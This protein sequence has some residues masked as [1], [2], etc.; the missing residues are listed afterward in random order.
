MGALSSAVAASQSAW[1][2]SSSTSMNRRHQGMG[3]ALKAE[4][5]RLVGGHHLAGPAT[6]NP[7]RRPPTSP[8]LAGRDGDHVL[9]ST[10]AGRGKH[11]NLERDARASVTIL[12][13]DAPY[14]DVELR[15]HTTI[16]EDVGRKF[17]TGLW[18]KYD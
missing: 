18:W 5:P 6:V 12:D 9:F 1:S 4:S 15:G 2:R 10:V 17:G 7:H 13:A 16:V 3:I 14:N 8:A 11:R